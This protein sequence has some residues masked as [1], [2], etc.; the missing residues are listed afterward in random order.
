MPSELNALLRKFES[1]AYDNDITSV[2]KRATALELLAAIDRLLQDPDFEVNRDL[3]DGVSD[4]MR[5]MVV[6]GFVAQTSIMF[7]AIGQVESIAKIIGHHKP[8][9]GDVPQGDKDP[10]GTAGL[11][12][13]LK[14]QQ[15]ERN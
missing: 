9:A 5:R 1:V 11:G 6:A 4:D 8:K 12:D 7:Q 10:L 2:N 13:L 14:G 3:F 15:N